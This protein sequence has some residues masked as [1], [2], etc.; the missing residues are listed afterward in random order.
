MK[1][2]KQVFQVMSAP[3]EDFGNYK[4]KSPKF[5]HWFKWLSPGLFVKRWLLISLTGLC[6]AFLGLAIWGRLTPISRLIDFVSDFLS[7]TSQILPNYISGPLLLLI[8][9]FWY[10]GDKLRLL[11]QLLRF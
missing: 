9:S 11:I 7:F 8:G 2:V 4:R 6:F 10:F 3:N 5:N 1:S